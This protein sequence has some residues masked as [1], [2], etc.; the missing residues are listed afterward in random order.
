MRV[1]GRKENVRSFLRSLPKDELFSTIVET[2]RNNKILVASAES[3]FG[4]KI[5][6]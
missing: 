1:F 6:V 5:Y 3:L 4:V 2:F